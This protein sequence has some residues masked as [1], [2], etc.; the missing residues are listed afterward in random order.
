ML[1]H[2]PIQVNHFT[3]ASD[4]VCGEK[5]SGSWRF[6]SYRTTFSSLASRWIFL[7]LLNH[8]CWRFE[9]FVAVE[10]FLSAEVCFRNFLFQLEKSWQGNKFPRWVIE[11]LHGFGDF[12]VLHRSKSKVSTYGAFLAIC[13][14]LFSL[15]ARA[16]KHITDPAEGMYMLSGHI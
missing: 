13:F 7:F 16:Q 1:P 4:A 12:C 14:C 2:L 10:L 3:I 11:M 5:H 8:A 6:L 15:L 9:S